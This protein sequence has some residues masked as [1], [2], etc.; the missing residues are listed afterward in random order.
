VRWPLFGRA[1]HPRIAPSILRHARPG[2]FGRKSHLRSL[3]LLL[4]HLN[5]EQRAEFEKSGVI[6]VVGSDTG[7]RYAIRVGSSS[8]VECRDHGDYIK[9]FCFLPRGNLP[10]GDVMLAQKLALELFES[11]ALGVARSALR[12]R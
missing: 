1:D 3:A 12:R 7:T 9:T 8:N 5:P 4:D 10:I 2:W 11:E 6:H